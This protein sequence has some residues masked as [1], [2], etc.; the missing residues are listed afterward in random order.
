MQR[1]RYRGA[2]PAVTACVA[3]L[4]ML[5][6]AGCGSS[7]PGRLGGGTAGGAA[8]GATFGLIG[9]PI[10][11]LVGGAIGGGIGALTAS[12]TSPKQLNLGPPPWNGGSGQAQAE[13]L[14][15]EPQ[16]VRSYQQ[17]YRQEPQQLQ[18][19]GY[20]AQPNLAPSQQ[21]QAQPLPPPNP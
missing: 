11:V 18:P 12:N 16:S 19:P 15:T 14:P 3:L 7:A 17:P 4:S 8:T 6:L 1:I 10:G 5:G 20:Q 13:A 9:G 21:V 2:S